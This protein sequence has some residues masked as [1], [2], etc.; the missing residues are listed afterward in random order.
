MAVKLL[1]TSAGL[2]EMI[3]A[4]QSG[5]DHVVISSCQF[6]SGKY[7]PTQAATAL[8]SPFKTLSTVSGG[9]VGGNI[10]HIEVTDAS[11]TQY[12]V[13]EVGLFSSSGTLIA[14]ASQATPIMIKAA[15]ATALLA[16]DI[17]LEDISV[18]VL[19]FGDTTYLNPPATESV[20]GVAEIAT[21]TE[22]DTGT[23]DT[24]IVTPKKL[25]SWIA[26][27]LAP[28]LKTSALLNKTYP[29][30]AVYISTVSTNPGTLFGGTWTQIQGKFLLAA[31]S[32]YAAGSTGGE[33]SHTLTASEMPAHNHGGSSGNAGGHTPAGRISQHTHAITVST[34]GANNIV[35]NS[36]DAAAWGS[37][38]KT[39]QWKSDIDRT[40]DRGVYACT[41]TVSPTATAANASLQFTGTAVAAHSHTISSQGGGAAHNNMPPYLAVYV[42]K[43]TA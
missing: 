16:F 11:A 10:V 31:S 21:Q 27:K 41:L 43:R 1:L 15:S 5:T 22:V 35:L 32:S 38:A 14:I 26:T 4:D 9:A 37:V 18:D 12:S 42:W 30:G 36:P 39:E 28:Y 24:R 40:G 2:D 34:G 3:S 29:V 13:Y 7:T 6:G 20:Q 33:A 17:A 8:R 23:D 19:Q 25:L